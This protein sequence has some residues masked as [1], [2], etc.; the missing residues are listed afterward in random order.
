[1]QSTGNT[2]L[3]MIVEM[4]A[5][6][7]QPVIDD[8]ETSHEIR[9]TLVLNDFAVDCLLAEIANKNKLIATLMSIPE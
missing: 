4:V 1:M 5:E 3:D 6:R 7:T 9:V 2:S 8:T